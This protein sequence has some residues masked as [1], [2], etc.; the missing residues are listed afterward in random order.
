MR[1]AF[2]PVRTDGAAA[3]IADAIRA[4]IVEGRLLSDE[5]L[6]VEAE[7][8]ARFGVSRPTMREAL[9]RL[10]AQNLIRSRR[11]P[12]GGTFV[13]RIGEAEARAQLAATA[14]LFIGMNDVDP[15]DVIEAR[16]A[17]ETACLPLAA[18]RRTPEHLAEMR[19]ALARQTDP[20]IS[21][22]A[23]CDADV[24]FHRALA[25][26][27]CNPMLAVQ[28]A[29]AAEA[30]QPLLNMITYRA[31]DRR[32]IVARHAALVT[33]L[34]ARDGVEA[35]RELTALAAYVGGLVRDGSQKG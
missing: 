21:D 4:A 28:A 2:E 27:T 22:E 1:I 5:R 7:L 16:T 13:N 34:E 14:T 10:A 20:E 24:R 25:E 12:A 3:Q 9:K 19:A 30:L 15:S 6:P 35:G 11:G 32:E 23:F 33:A 17:L 31:R 26:A 18:A 8:A 29:G